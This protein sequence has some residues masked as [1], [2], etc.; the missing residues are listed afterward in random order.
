MQ[1]ISCA[2]RVG[3]ECMGIH[4]RVIPIHG[5]AKLQGNGEKIIWARFG[6]SEAFLVVL[7]SMVSEGFEAWDA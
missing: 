3:H 5:P 7:R 4:S 6:S 2:R 1:N